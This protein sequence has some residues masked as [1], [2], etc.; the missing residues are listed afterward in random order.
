MF[1]W[2]SLF[3]TSFLL[4][5]F[6]CFVVL[7]FSITSSKPEDI[8]NL[9][10]NGSI[11]QQRQEPKRLRNSRH[12][13]QSQ[14][15]VWLWQHTETR[16][17]KPRSSRTTG[18]KQAIKNITTRQLGNKATQNHHHQQ[19]QQQCSPDGSIAAGSVRHSH[20]IP[21][22]PPSPRTTNPDPLFGSFWLPTKILLFRRPRRGVP[23]H[24]QQQQ[25][26]LLLLPTTVTAK[27]S[28]AFTATTGRRCTVSRHRR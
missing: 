10:R 1:V 5:V 14:K 3:T 13:Q 4:F 7:I 25:H 24:R 8:L 22:P 21:M 20:R 9:P 12:R 23:F 17:S 2:L 11:N 18:S 28:S 16:K 19:Q 26:Q 15:E 6:W 27:R